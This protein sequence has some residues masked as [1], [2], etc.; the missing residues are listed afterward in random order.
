MTVLDKNLQ[1]SDSQAL[2]AT[3]VSTN[4]YDATTDRDLGPGE[5][6]AMVVYAETVL[7]GTTPTLAVSIQTDDNSGF[8]SA[9][10]LVTSETFT[11]LTVGQIIVIPLTMDNER[12]L[13][14]NYTLG[15]TSPTATVS[16][17]LQPLSTVRN[18]RYYPNNYTITS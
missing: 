1:F 9:A 16:A 8:S 10:T 15:G 7:G 12:Y 17:Y 6:M 2:T 4:I 5:P 18:Q 11:E 14:L 3:A 13:R